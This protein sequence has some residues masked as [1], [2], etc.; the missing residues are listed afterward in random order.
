MK[1]TIVNIGAVLAALCIGLAINSAC[2]DNLGKASAS[3]TENMSDSELRSL[4]AQLQQEVNS[5]KQEVTG[6]KQRVAELEGKMGSNTGG[7][8]AAASGFDV[9]GLHFDNA[10]FVEQPVDYYVQSGYTI[11][12]GERTDSPAQTFRYTYDSKGRITKQGNTSYS[13]S[14]KTVTMT[15]TSK[16]DNYENSITQECHYK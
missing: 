9:D 16:S 2:A 11:I 15:S 13:Y 14:G 6:L 1:K 10:G 7:G 4:V 12:N 5:L 8:S 3:S